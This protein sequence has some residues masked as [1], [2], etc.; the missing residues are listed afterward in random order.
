MNGLGGAVNVIF[1]SHTGASI[2]SRIEGGSVWS[3]RTRAHRPAAPTNKLIEQ[4]DS[5]RDHL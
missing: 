5:G 2:N 4:R 1:G 3:F